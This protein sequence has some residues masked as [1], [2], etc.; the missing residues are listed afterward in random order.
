MNR[1]FL[2][3]VLFAVLLAQPASASWCGDR[4]RFFF[5]GTTSDRAAAAGVRYD[6]ALGAARE[7]VRQK[8]ALEPP[9]PR[10]NISHLAGRWALDSESPEH[11]WTALAELI[12]TKKNPQEVVW[13]LRDLGEDA[14][15]DELEASLLDYL[16]NGRIVQWKKLWNYPATTKKKWSATYENGL[17]AIVKRRQGLAR[18]QAEVAR[19]ELSKLLGVFVPATAYRSHHGTMYCAQIGVGGPWDRKGVQGNG[20]VVSVG[21]Q[22]KERKREEAYDALYVFDFVSAQGDFWLGENMLEQQKRYAYVDG[23]ESF[24]PAKVEPYHLKQYVEKIAKSTDAQTKK[25]VAALRTVD[26]EKVRAALAPHLTPAEVQQT[27]D[28]IRRVRELLPPP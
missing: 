26:V 28:H 12:E 19:F 27:I 20:T 6:A 10:P 11:P 7:F 4:L 13:R 23:V 2:W 21:R 17:T 18:P 1:S 3:V 9:L 15:A 5:T 8:S 16:E 25:F 22:E 24:R 14:L